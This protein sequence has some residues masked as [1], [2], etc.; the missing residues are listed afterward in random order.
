MGGMMFMGPSA[1]VEEADGFDQNEYQ[2]ESR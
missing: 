2:E 1:S